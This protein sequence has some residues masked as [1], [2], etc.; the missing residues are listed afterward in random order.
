MKRLPVVF[1]LA[2]L[3]A[4]IYS[5]DNDWPDDLCTCHHGGSIDGW[6]VSDT[7]DVFKKDSTGGFEIEV[8][9]WDNSETHDIEL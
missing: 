7:T 1:L 4:C 5:C 9:N 3:S 2:A 8:E 6:D